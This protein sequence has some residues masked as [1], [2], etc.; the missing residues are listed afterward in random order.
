MHSYSCVTLIYLSEL[1]LQTD[2]LP[3]FLQIHYRA[4][5]ERELTEDYAPVRASNK[6]KKVTELIDNDLY[7]T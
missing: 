1:L 7:G 2:K 5:D 6:K 3:F 4:E